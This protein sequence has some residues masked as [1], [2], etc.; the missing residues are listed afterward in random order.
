MAVIGG[1]TEVWTFLQIMFC[2]DWPPQERRK[3]HDIDW[4]SLAVAEK[5]ISN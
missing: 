3:K 2:V 4:T 5:F 1:S